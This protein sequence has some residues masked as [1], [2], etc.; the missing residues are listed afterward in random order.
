MDSFSFQ[1]TEYEDEKRIPLFPFTL[2][3]IPSPSLEAIQP[4]GWTME[5][6][7]PHI[8][9]VQAALE[10]DDLSLIDVPEG[11][12]A[13]EMAES[14][15]QI[16]TYAQAGV[17]LISDREKLIRDEV[18]RIQTLGLRTI[19]GARI[20]LDSEFRIIEGLI[21]CWALQA[22]G[23]TGP[24]GVIVRYD[25]DPYAGLHH[26][27]QMM[28]QSQER[29]IDLDYDRIQELLAE[30]TPEERKLLATM[31]HYPTRETVTLRLSRDTFTRLSP[32]ITKQLGYE[33]ERA[34]KK[35]KNKRKK[36]LG[37]DDLSIKFDPA[38]LLYVDALSQQ[39]SIAREQELATTDDPEFAEKSQRYLDEEQRASDTGEKFL[40]DLGERWTRHGGGIFTHWVFPRHRFQLV[41]SE[42]EQETPQLEDPSPYLMEQSQFRIFA[43]AHFGMR[44]SDADELHAAE[45][46]DGFNR[47]LRH[48]IDAT[49]TIYE[50]K[51][52][53]KGKGLIDEKTPK[54]MALSD[55][56]ERL[57]RWNSASK[58]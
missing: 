34:M 10:A 37:R 12:T 36:K 22:L 56:E 17:A 42:P 3:K 41:E 5:D 35:K 55:Q 40:K 6:F 54:R 28:S 39:I 25:T 14:V 50:D 52:K 23:F 58:N 21:L 51:G 49:P 33:I 45:G 4:D 7:G 20:V 43:N 13:E 30:A 15:E 9:G 8:G 27:Q 31:G 1:D 2:I 26:I 11:L 38:Q 53:S 19:V 46:A 24:V 32:L 18:E 48:Y 16:L 29:R 57:K 47:K 44:E